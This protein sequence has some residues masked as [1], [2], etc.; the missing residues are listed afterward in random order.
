MC[1]RDQTQNCLFI[2]RSRADVVVDGVLRTRLAMIQ[3]CL[4]SPARNVFDQV[5]DGHILP[6]TAFI[7]QLDLYWCCCKLVDAGLIIITIMLA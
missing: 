2:R 1:W 7:V 5:R 6:Y 3:R 4:S